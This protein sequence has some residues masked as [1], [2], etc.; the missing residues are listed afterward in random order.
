MLRG[1]KALKDQDE[2]AGDAIIFIY[3]A[4]KLSKTQLKQDF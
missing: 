1:N 2:V 4:E 3:E